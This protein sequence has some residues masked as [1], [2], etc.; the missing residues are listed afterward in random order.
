MSSEQDNHWDSLASDLSG[1]ESNNDNDSPQDD[2]PDPT[3]HEVSDLA[4]EE[5]VD[6]NQNQSASSAPNHSVGDKGD[7]LVET[8][9]PSVEISEETN[10]VDP[11]TLEE[12]LS[13]EFGADIKPVK[14]DPEEGGFGVGLFGEE[15]LSQIRAEN[16]KARQAKAEVAAVQQAD[17]DLKLGKDELEVV[18]NA[19]KVNPKEQVSN[20]PSEGAEEEISVEDAKGVIE[21][22]ESTGDDVV[23]ALDRLFAPVEIGGSLDDTREGEIVFES[24]DVDDSLEFD[25]SGK[26]DADPI[27]PEGFSYTDVEGTPV[28]DAVV[29]K[30]DETEEEAEADQLEEEAEQI[31]DELEAD[32][33]PSDKP[34]KKT[35]RRKRRIW[36]WSR[37]RVEE[38]SEDSLP[39]NTSQETQTQSDAQGSGKEEASVADESDAK[40]RSGNKRRGKRRRKSS[41]AANNSHL[42]NKSDGSIEE[43]SKEK[44]SADGSGDKKTRRGGSRRERGRRDNR[45]SAGSDESRDTQD[46]EGLSTD[47]EEKPKRRRGNIPTWDTAVSYVVDKNVKARG[48]SIP[49][50]ERINK[51]RRKSDSRDEDR[52]REENVSNEEE[53]GKSYSDN[54][55]GK[56]K[57]DKG[58]GRNRRRRGKGNQRKDGNRE[59]NA[60]KSDSVKKSN[61]A[62]SKGDDREPGR[63]GSRKRSRKRSDGRREAS[64]DASRNE[65]IE[66]KNEDLD[67]SGGDAKKPNRRRRRRRSRLDDAD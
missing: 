58:R 24:E 4:N 16:D 54:Q 64:K 2:K 67:G 46:N 26:D 3:V 7:E 66:K 30:P 10:V 60:G 31:D 37:K 55:S 22:L 44:K 5:S 65:S 62:G 20:Q 21:N 28:Q 45:G 25:E 8:L 6:A 53:R 48:K 47:N 56:D 42:E 39:D 52:D 57:G 29:P 12:D 9:T 17:R 63:E 15:E 41:N 35:R 51:K 1:E 33:N 23:A 50:R 38:D 32:V 14:T 11:Q 18:P 36:P 49:K 40:E 43:T 59:G 19:E 34:Q 27:T 61:D 13:D